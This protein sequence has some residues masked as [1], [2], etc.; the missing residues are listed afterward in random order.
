MPMKTHV[1][2]VA[3]LHIAL[4]AI[5]LLG[6]VAIFFFFGMATAVVSAQGNPHAAGITAVVGVALAGFLAVVSLPGILG[7]WALYSERAWGR[8]VILVLSILHVL[9]FPFGTALSLYSFWALLNEPQPTSPG[10]SGIRT[11]T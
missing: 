9:N 8:P 3:I 1:Q 4:G 6:A 10:A 11:A 7:G 5:S 2:V